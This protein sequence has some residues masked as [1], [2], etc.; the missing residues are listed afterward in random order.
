ML[1][2]PLVLLCMA[3]GGHALDMVRLDLDFSP[4]DSRHLYPYTVLEHALE[5]TLD[6]H[7][8]YE[9]SHC[10][11][12]MSRRRILAEL[13]RGEQINVHIAATQPEWESET[14]AIRIPVLKGL[15][16]YRLFL[17]R[18]ENLPIFEKIRTVDDL[19]QLRTGSGGQWTTTRVLRKAGFDVVTGSDY[20][21]LFGMLNMKRF[22]Y[23]PRGI[24]EIY[25]ELAEQKPE[26]P[27]LCVEPGLAL[28]FPTP[29][30]FFISPKEPDL[31]ERIQKGMETILE[32]GTLDAVFKKHF[33][34]AIA[35]A[36]LKSRRI[37]V[38]SNPLLSPK[39]P[40]DRKELWY[41]P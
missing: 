9:I 32:N 25:Q 17:I 23:F 11:M 18:E 39:T 27:A 12:R 1:L 3:T 13:I 5:A 14:I 26:Y 15:L 33:A 2:A 19:R 4:N 36:D 30:Y 8:P 24:N 6:T 7:G 38:I 29:S 16:G 28:Y 34:D 40:L 35:R 10:K 37:L 21:G 20:L 31:A 41:V 22:D